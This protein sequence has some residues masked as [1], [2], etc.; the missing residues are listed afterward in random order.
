M[1]QHT[2]LLL[3]ANPEAMPRLDVDDESR[4]IRIALRQ[5]GHGDAFKG[6]AQPCCSRYS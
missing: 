5:K 2:I 3:A 4:D 6:T 1:N